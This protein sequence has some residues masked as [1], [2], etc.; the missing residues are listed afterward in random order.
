MTADAAPRW[1]DFSEADFDASRAPRSAARKRAAGDGQAGLFSSRRPS[2]MGNR[3][4]TLWEPL[5]AVAD[6]AGGRWLEAARE[7]CEELTASEGLP[8]SE[9]LDELDAM[10]A[11]WE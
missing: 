9:G 1:L 8:G 5:L 6:A 2:G 3:P 11:G 10:M 4:A 7:A